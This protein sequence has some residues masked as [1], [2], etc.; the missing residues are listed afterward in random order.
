MTDTQTDG[1]TTAKTRTQR[2]QVR[3]V[4]SLCLCVSQSV[5]QSVCHTKRVERSTDGN[6][7]LVFTKLTKVESWEMCLLLT[8][9]FWWK[10]EIR[11]PAKPEVEL[12]FIIAPVVK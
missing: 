7:T 10:S 3:V 4:K 9:C 8:Y 12:I 6:P 1:I 2:G 11:M 5:S